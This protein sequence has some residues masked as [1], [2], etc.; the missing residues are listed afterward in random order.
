MAFSFSVV[1]RLAQEKL[2]RYFWPIFCVFTI[3]FLVIFLDH[4]RVYEAKTRFV[5]IHTESGTEASDMSVDTIARMPETLFFYD[6][7][8]ATYPEVNDPWKDQE[9]SDREVSWQKHIDAQR[10]DGSGVIEVTLRADSSNDAKLLADR[11]SDTLFRM[12]SRY[13]DIRTQLE[14]RRLGDPM[15][16]TSIDAALGWLS[17]S[18]GLGALAAFAL[19]SFGESLQGAPQNSNNPE[20]SERI[21]EMLTPD[22]K[23]YAALKDQLNITKKVG[24]EKVLEETIPSVPVPP[25]H[26]LEPIR[27][28]PVAEVKS[29]APSN[30]PFLQDG[31]SLEQYLFTET[32]PTTEEPF[33]TPEE[34]SLET[35]EIP[36]VS[37]PVVAEEKPVETISKEP[38][39]EE[40]KNRLNQLLRGEM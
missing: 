16:Q 8:L 6:Q 30:L 12:V 3:A 34:A 5:V 10:Q 29:A 36:E 4:F 7:L 32:S 35:V 15:I 20:L 33:E 25:I 22:E 40:L 27:T 13:Y 26:V 19:A 23:D 11:V 1:S 31:M 38:T 24:E 2:P 39:E 14:I 21:R 18:V 28:Q 37:N 17:I 9:T